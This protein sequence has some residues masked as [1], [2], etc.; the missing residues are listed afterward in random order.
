MVEEPFT[1][2]YK[3]GGKIIKAGGNEGSQLPH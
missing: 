1:E 3:L 2:K